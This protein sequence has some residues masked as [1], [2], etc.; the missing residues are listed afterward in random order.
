MNKTKLMIQ[1]AKFYLEHENKWI[2]F[3][4]DR[5]TVGVICNLVNIRVLNVNEFG[6]AKVNASNANLW[7]SAKG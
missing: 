5:Q 1:A 7:L 4:T 2:A 6:Q 3:A